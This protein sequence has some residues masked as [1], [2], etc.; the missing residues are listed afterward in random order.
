MEN[1][2]LERRKIVAENI[3]KLIKEKGITQ[4]QLAKE[5]GMSQNII[6]EYVKLRSFPPGGVLQKIADYFGVKKSDIDTTWKKDVNSE[7][8]PYIN[9]TIDNMKKLTEE[10]QENILKFSKMQLD[11]QNE[12]IEKQKVITINN[13]DSSDIDDDGIDWNEWVAFDGRP[14]SDHDKQIIKEHLGDELKD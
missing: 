5:I 4:K 10:R 9:E 1:Y 7:Y 14:M 8:T 6:T 12:A 2:E 13:K 3:K 11:E